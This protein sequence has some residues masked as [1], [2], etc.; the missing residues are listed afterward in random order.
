MWLGLETECSHLKIQ[1]HSRK[2][3]LER[4]Q[5]SK[6]VPRGI[7]LL[8]RPYILSFK[9][10]TSSRANIQIPQ[11]MGSISFKLPKNLSGLTHRLP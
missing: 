8:A 10:D 11:N 9:T 7:L 6:T 2:R 1:E 3:T 4:A 5:S